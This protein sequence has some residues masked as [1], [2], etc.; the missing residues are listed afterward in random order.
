[1]GSVISTLERKT[2]VE[3][4]DSLVAHSDGTYRCACEL[5]GGDNPSSFTVFPDTNSYYCWGCGAHG[6]GVIAY[7]MNRDNISFQEA[8]HKLCDIY[9]LTIDDSD[10][11]REQ[12]TVVDRNASWVKAMEHELPSIVDYLHKRGLT[13]ETIA[14]YHLGY[15]PKL[16]ALSI[17]MYDEWMRPVAFLYRFFDKTPKYKNSK[18]QPGLFI[19]GEMLYGLPQA[20]KFLKDRREVMLCEGAFDC[21]SAVQQGNCCV[22]YCGITVSRHHVEAVRDI[23]APIKGGKLTLCPDNDNKAS[24]FVTRA[25]DLFRRFAPKLVV[26]VAVIP[27][28]CKDFN[29]ML[30]MGKDIAADC[31]YE[32]IDLYCA[33]QL[34]RD[35][36]DREVQ[37]KAIVEYCHSVNNPLVM[38][39][40]ATYLAGVWQRDISVVRELLAIREDTSEEKLHDI[41]TMDKAYSALE[42]RKDDETFGIGYENI[43]KTMQLTRK[44]VFVIGAY[45]FSGKCL[46]EGSMI[47][48][49]SGSKKIEDITVGEQIATLNESTGLIELDSVGDVIDT[50]I[51]QGFKVMTRTGRSVTVSA[52]HPFLTPNGWVRV[53]DGLST[54]DSIAL[55]LEMPNEGTVDVPDRDIEFLALMIADGFCSCNSIRYTKSNEVMRDIF[56]GICASFNTECIESYSDY[57]MSLH[58]PKTCGAIDVLTSYGTMGKHSWDKEI[59]WQ[60][61]RASKDK[62]KKFIELLWSGDGW[63]SAS[64]LAYCTTSE[65]LANQLV[66]MLQEFGI[67]SQ[68][69]SKIPKCNGKECRTAYTVSVPRQFQ[70]KFCE[71]FDINKDYSFSVDPSS[72]NHVILG[73]IRINSDRADEV[74]KHYDGR[75]KRLNEILGR[76]YNAKTRCGLVGKRHFTKVGFSKRDIDTIN[77]DCHSKALKFAAYDG[78]FYD[79]VSSIEK[80]G[81]VHMYDIAMPKNHNFIANNIIVHNTDNLLEMILYWCIALRK[82]CLFFSLEMPMEDIAKIIVAK[83]VQIPRYKVKEYIS[84]HK[85]TYQLILEKLQDSLYIVDKNGL[86]LDDMADYVRLIKARGVDL[87]IVAVDYFQYLRGVDDISAQ[88]AEAQKM[89]AFAKELNVTLVMLSQLRKASQ[90]KDKSG[91]WHEPVQAD[92]AGAGG[93]GNSAD[94]IVLLWRPALNADLSPIDA[95]KAK[96]D[97]VI[98]LT[99]ARE[100]RNGNIMFTLEYNPETSR[101][102]EKVTDT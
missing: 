7:T 43:D 36:P 62:Q 46:A 27:D 22:A 28:G 1:M 93:I 97:T 38:Q 19:K 48:T 23:L 88:E 78:V 53:C 54:K 31:T 102:T 50:G 4:I 77:N 82:K 56:R 20:R 64:E 61:R 81:D 95:E 40:I 47:K 73:R 67:I 25:R 69:R 18:N 79:E 17:P 70:Q 65:M 94:Y 59:P 99:K 80:V 89:K 30:V 68:I 75:H 12:M 24:K 39:D 96:Y 10:E 32:N 63:L 76:F 58:N 92:I 85:E 6:R 51:K 29:D 60:I 72:K 41:A 66:E 15:A 21:M 11:Y 34:I 37:E 14:A 45:S 55:P 86:T 2:L 84:E 8:V 49:A 33:K 3:Y 26:K 100:V 42:Q 101:L 98:K 44:S 35:E 57:D 87:D 9:G 13:D 16:S 90:S 71:V 91:K 74:L 5:H 52:E 83:V